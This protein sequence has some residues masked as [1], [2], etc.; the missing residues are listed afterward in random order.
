MIGIFYISPKSVHTT[1]IYSKDAQGLN[2]YCSSLI[3]VNTTASVLHSMIGI[4][5]ISPKSVHTADIYS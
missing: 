3:Y 1:E 5:Y 4:F 2:N